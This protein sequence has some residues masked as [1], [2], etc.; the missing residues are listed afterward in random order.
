MIIPKICY[1]WIAKQRTDYPGDLE[2]CFN[3]DME[4]TFR[5]IE[6][7][8]PIR[9][10]S[11]L[12]VGCG[13]GGIDVLLWNL[14]RPKIWLMD[15]E[16]VTKPIYGYNKGPSFYNSFEATAA[17]MDANGVETYEQWPAEK[18][19]PPVKADLTISLLSLG[20]HYPVETYLDRITGPLLIDLR[21]GTDGLDRVKARYQSVREI[22]RENKA[23]TVL[24]S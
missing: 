23:L 18:G 1:P 12:D 21:E 7:F 4:E 10:E 17:L 2:E 15:Y 24:A 8:L 19:F 14:F 13:V 9:L 6:P 3:A 20:Y 5:A 16:K 22:R 11:V